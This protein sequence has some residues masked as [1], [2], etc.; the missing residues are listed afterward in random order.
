LI[1]PLNIDCQTLEAEYLEEIEDGYLYKLT[2][3]PLTCDLSLEAF[4]KHLNLTEEMI[5]TI[6]PFQYE[7]NKNDTSV[8]LIKIFLSEQPSVLNITLSHLNG[9][10]IIEDTEPEAQEDEAEQIGQID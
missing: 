4:L 9:T 3:L 2:L 10:I 5:K 6:Q 8:Y 7:V 1:N